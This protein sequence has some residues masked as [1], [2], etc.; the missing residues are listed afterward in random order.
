MPKMGIKK[1][2]I[3]MTRSDEWITPFLQVK[4]DEYKQ[5]CYKNCPH[6]DTPCNGTCKEIIDWLKSHNR[7]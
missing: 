5:F 6:E 3:S 2:V 7:R 1:R 4:D